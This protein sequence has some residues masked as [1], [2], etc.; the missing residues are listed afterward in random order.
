MTL[1]LMKDAPKDICRADVTPRRVQQFKPGAGQKVMWENLSLDG[2]LIEKGEAVVDSV[3]LI[4]LNQ[5]TV[6]KG[7]NRVVV[8]R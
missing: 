8:R 6:A 7:G 4:T 3:G 1:N 5:I 2:R